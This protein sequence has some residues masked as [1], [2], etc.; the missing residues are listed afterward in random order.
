MKPTTF[1]SKKRQRSA[2]KPQRTNLEMLRTTAAV[3]RDLLPDGS[4]FPNGHVLEA[5]FV[6]NTGGPIDLYEAT[7]TIPSYP[8]LIQRQGINLYIGLQNA[9]W[10]IQ[11]TFQWGR[12]R[13]GGDYNFWHLVCMQVNID[14]TIQPATAISAAVQPGDTFKASISRVASPGGQST[15]TMAFDDGTSLT[16]NPIDDILDTAAISLETYG[17]QSSTNYPANNQST[18]S[19][20][21]IN[22]GNIL[23]QWQDNSAGNSNG[24]QLIINNA[25]PATVGIKFR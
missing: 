1:T 20:I 25:Q 6:N 8:S 10:L 5:D 12:S 7:F 4:G 3:S 19:Q 15:Y 18:F 9:N 2:K 22:G 11:C 24:E 16:G 14:P 21:A 17:V 23:P 13:A